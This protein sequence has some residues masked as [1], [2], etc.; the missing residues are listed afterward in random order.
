MGYDRE[1]QLVLF[2]ESVRLHFGE[3][4]NTI[5]KKFRRVANRVNYLDEGKLEKKT[6]K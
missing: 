2:T 1:R 6:A 5:L 3:V 4:L